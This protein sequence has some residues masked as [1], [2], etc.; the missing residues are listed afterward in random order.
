MRK[1][2]WTAL[3]LLFVF[4]V[5]GRTE[6]V[7]GG[8]NDSA[9]SHIDNT[10]SGQETEGEANA[11]TK[12][13]TKADTQA[14]T[15]GEIIFLLDGSGS[16][17]EQGREQTVADAIRKAVYSLPFGYEA[18]LV[19][20]STDILAAAAPGM[21]M[22][23]LEELLDGIR[24][25]GY[26]N[27]GAGLE[28]AMGL[29]SERDGV[30]RWIV[31]LSDGEIDMPDAQ[32]IQ[33]S[34][35]RYVEAAR[36]A[37][38][39][40]IKIYIVAL[41]SELKGQEHHIFDGAEL[42]DGAI[43][44]EGQSGSVGQIL[45]DI[46]EKRMGIP[47]GASAMPAQEEGILHIPVPKGA[48]RVRLLLTEE[49]GAEG[50]DF[51]A[52]EASFEAEVSK[53]VTGEGFKVIELEDPVCPSI[54]IRT[55]AEEVSGLKAWLSTEIQG[56]L[57][58]EAAYKIEEAVSG[59]QEVARG[60]QEAASGTRETAPGS[61]E[62]I[63]PTYVHYVDITIRLVSAADEGID[64][65]QDPVFDGMEVELDI[66]G[67]P[68]TETV[69]QGQ[70][71]MRLPADGIDQLELSV[72]AFQEA[73]PGRTFL[74]Q[75][76]LRIPI[77]KYPDPEPVAEPEPEQEW[78][79]RPLIAIFVSLAVALTGLMV[80]WGKRKPMV[81]VYTSQPPEI[82]GAQKKVDAKAFSYSGK[83]NLYM[84]KTRDGS[85]IPPQTYRLFGRRS[86]QLTLAQILAACKVRPGKIGAEEIILYPG[87][88]HS[89]IF[90]D[91]SQDCT[92]MRGM[93]ILKKGI[94]YPVFYNEKVTVSFE[95]GDTEME[96]Y[97]KSLKPSEMK[98]E[99]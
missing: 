85:D 51:K 82:S 47:R 58:A 78:D 38:E 3:L 92:V 29:F 67:A 80:W 77:E 28:Q 73:I 12:I 11:E 95:D 6:G 16:M 19:V 93:E 27:A 26:T 33:L 44:W 55:E 37:Q 65:W 2:V 75:Q 66:N 56:R 48:S 52:L 96:I 32:G 30:D 70:I 18:G 40:G 54:D 34:R 71:Q 88:D 20:Y 50:T 86:G 76:P 13:E 21:D 83:L 22:D 25:A 4:L 64:L 94:G 17:N 14:E 81:V 23:R 98:E 69:T 57:L 42:T 90:T 43:Y 9:D 53:T 7:Y 49:E 46:M 10:G 87:P 84:V 8:L 63:Q 5:W 68:Y 74:I 62:E 45:D 31:M 41:G 1:K 35:Q 97:Y 91:R 60:T 99:Y 39:K 79:S 36:Q 89:V 61:G 72:L 15:K 59:T 24:Y